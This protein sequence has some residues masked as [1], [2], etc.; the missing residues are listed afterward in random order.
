MPK[1]SGGK[2]A[3]RRAFPFMGM[4]AAIAEA[5]T[6]STLRL[7]GGSLRREYCLWTLSGRS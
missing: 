6:I 7:P 1:I 2:K 5:R 4:C 3:G